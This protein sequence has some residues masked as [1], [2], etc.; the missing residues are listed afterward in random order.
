MRCTEF[1][2]NERVWLLQGN[3][4]E[5]YI[6]RSIH[7]PEGGEKCVPLKKDDKY[8]GSEAYSSL[9]SLA[10]H[11]SLIELQWCRYFDQ[12]TSSS[13]ILRDEWGKIKPMK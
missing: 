5:R 1:E 10:N 8:T 12:F 13:T 4:Q 3:G 2:S 9:T 7:F 6:V 11:D